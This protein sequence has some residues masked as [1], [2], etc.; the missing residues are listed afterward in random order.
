M[1]VKQVYYNLKIT[2]IGGYLMDVVKVSELVGTSGE[3]WTDAV[4]NAVVEAAKNRDD[5]LGVEV[6]NF[7]ANIEN[8]RII[9][10]KANIKIASHFQR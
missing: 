3:N 2:I 10:Y 5:I 4:N 9:E 7:T 1:L 6:I 8:G